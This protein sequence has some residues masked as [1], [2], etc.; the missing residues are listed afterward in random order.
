M[1]TRGSDKKRYGVPSQKREED[2][3]NPEILLNFISYIIKD[4]GGY[5]I[6][7]EILRKHTKRPDKKRRNAVISKN[8][9]YQVVNDE[10]YIRYFHLDAISNKLRVPIFT[11][12]A[13]TRILSSSRDLNAAR[14]RGDVDAVKKNKTD[15]ENTAK[16]C[17]IISNYIEEQIDEN[18][19]QMK[20]ID[21]LVKKIE[22]EGAFQY[23]SQD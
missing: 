5:R 4:L 7:T 13:F 21:I 9:Y 11:I 12:L 22:S 20:D 8:S 2:K 1:K 14:E 10:T 23:Y 15:I 19:F 16:I 3:R 18:S 6:A 17:K